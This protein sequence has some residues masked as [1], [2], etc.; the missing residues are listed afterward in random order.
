[1]KTFANTSTVLITGRNERTKNVYLKDEVLE[2]GQEPTVLEEKL[3]E[4]TKHIARVVKRKYVKITTEKEWVEEVLFDGFC[5]FCD[6][7][8]A[9]YPWFTQNGQTF[10]LSEA[11][12]E[13]KEIYG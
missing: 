11:T 6:D 8:S 12:D 1:M 10:T 7:G 3:V 2:E 13:D 4:V 5:Y 9:Y